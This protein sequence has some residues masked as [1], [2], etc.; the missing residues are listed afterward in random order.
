LLT[1]GGVEPTGGGPLAGWAR[2]Q[3]WKAVALTTR[4]L[5]RISECPAPHN[6]VHS[7]G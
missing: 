6:S 1:F 7:T 3:L 5:E 4:T 2:S